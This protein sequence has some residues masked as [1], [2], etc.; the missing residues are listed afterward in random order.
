MVRGPLIPDPPDRARWLSL[1]VVLLAL[2]AVV[3]GFFDPG[4][5]TGSR[6]IEPAA[7]LQSDRADKTAGFAVP[8]EP[9]TPPRGP[10][11]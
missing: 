1:A 2:L 6:P 4:G 9:D 8:P 7:Q 11:R 3:F 5:G 10:G